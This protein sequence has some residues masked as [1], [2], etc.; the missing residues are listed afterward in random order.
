[1]II[2]PATLFGIRFADGKENIIYKQTAIYI[3]RQRYIEKDDDKDFGSCTDRCAYYLYY[4]AHP[5]RNKIITW[6]E[7]H[8]NKS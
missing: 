7:C 1:M 4:S 2:D 6:I 8:H 3:K 5:C